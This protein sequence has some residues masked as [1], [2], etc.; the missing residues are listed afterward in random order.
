MSTA[1]VDV[2]ALKKYYPVTGGVFRRRIAD[3]RAV[4]G[5]DLALDRGE[6]LGLV[7]ESGCGKTTLGKTILRL[8]KATEGRIYFDQDPAEVQKVEAMMRAE[9]PAERARGRALSRGMDLNR[10]S[11]RALLALRQKIQV[12]FQDPTNSLDPRMLVRDIVAEPLTAQHLVKSRDVESRVL[13]L[14]GI[15]GLTS[16]HLM[17]YPH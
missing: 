12:V 14:L 17:R 3:V 6:C 8:H 11:G 9:A 10:L 13:E 15:V 7:G 5:V 4:D 2:R 1:L 16:D